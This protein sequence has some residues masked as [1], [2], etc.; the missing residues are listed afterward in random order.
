VS[1]LTATAAGTF[2]FALVGDALGAPPAKTPAVT[3]V[4]PNA[5]PGTGG[6]EV[7]VSGKNFPKCTFTISGTTCNNLIVYF[8]S[9]PGLPVSSNGREI[10][11]F[12]PE[13]FSEVMSVD[14]RV[15]SAG[16]TSATT[17]ADHFAYT[18]FATVTPGEIPV[19]NSVEPNHG[20]H[21]G[22]TEVTI[23]G[24]HL[25]PSGNPCVECTGD[26]VR[27]GAKGVSVLRGTSTELVVP[28]PPQ[29]PGPENVSVST[30]PGGMSTSTVTYTY[31]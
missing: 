9:E 14:V 4:S 10:H 19:V 21:V 28:V 17:P 22:F 12:S 15:A 5:G 30:N 29:P 26:V 13:Q 23:K 18:G 24:E 2:A 11:V 31:E 16:G 1:I 20:S 25:T 27:F 7:N 8:G 6:T 3:A